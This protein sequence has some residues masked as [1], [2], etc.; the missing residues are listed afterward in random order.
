MRRNRQHRHAVAMAIVQAVDQVQV[1]WPA[2][3][4]A[5]RKLATGRRLGTGSEGCNFFVAG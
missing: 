2:A 4:R 3:A 1:T 5:D